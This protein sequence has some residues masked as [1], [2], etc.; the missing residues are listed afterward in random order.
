[1]SK[2]SLIAVA[3]ILTGWFVAAEV[4]DK[5]GQ[6]TDESPQ[7]LLAAVAQSG[8]GASG[9]SDG[10]TLIQRINE[11]PNSIPLNPDNPIK[12]V[13]V[14]FNDFKHNPKRDPGPIDIQR[15]TM[16]MQYQGIPTFFRAP[17]ALT[18][19]DLKAG[20]VDVAIMGASIDMSTG[21]RGAAFGPQALRTAERVGAWG[22]D[23]VDHFAHPHV[24]NIV[25]QRD[26][27]IVDYGDAPIDIQSQERS[28]PAVIKM[29]KEI[30]ETGT[31]PVII[32]GD[33]SLMYP[34]LVAL[35]DIHGKGNVGVVHFDA[36]FDG[37]EGFFGHYISHGSPVKLLIDEGHVKG[38]N[39]VQ[40]GLHSAIPGPESMEWMRKNRVRYH[41]MAEIEE[42]GWPAVLKDV[43]AEALD[44][45]KKLF[46]SI[47]LDCLEPAYSPGMGTPEPGGMTPMQVMTCV[48]GLAAQNEIIGVEL[49]EVNPIVD[50]SYLS[51]L[52]AV[53]TLGEALTGIAMRKKGITDPHYRDP[54]WKEHGVPMG[55]GN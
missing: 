33:H 18:P 14:L 10:K 48:R 27:N 36:H 16:G 42:R 52:V 4:A 15:T 34:D 45:P 6:N 5:H 20:K 40:V 53:R 50:P 8:V 9:A 39:F 2:I 19:E 51:S 21:M 30:A 29:V 1:M 31:I 25:F 3:M 54:H 26:L 28:F 49:V 35:T 44:G 38:K 46:L 13:R 41:M 7:V 22:R 17:V 55:G 32:G 12:D 11:S 47:D 23:A 24:G 43:L 37:E